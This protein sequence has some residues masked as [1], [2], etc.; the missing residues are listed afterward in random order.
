MDKSQITIPSFASRDTGEITA[1]GSQR[2][3][4]SAALSYNTS[5]F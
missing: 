2:I 4:H 3:Q 1:D 5:I